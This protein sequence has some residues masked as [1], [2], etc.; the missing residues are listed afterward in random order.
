MLLE[1][2]E[3]ERILAFI[4][5]VSLKDRIAVLHHHDSDGLCAAAIVF[6][7][8]ERIRGKKPELR[9]NQGHS[10]VELKDYTVKALKE[11]KI[12]KLF[13]VDLAV[14][15]T[16]KSVENLE[17]VLGFSS[18]AV[19]D[20]H[21]KHRE[22]SPEIIYVNAYELTDLAWKYPAS[23]MCYD[24]FSRRTDL[25]DVDWIACV[26]ILGDVSYKE[27]KEFVDKALEKG[28]CERKE[29]VYES[30]LGDIHYILTALE[31][32]DLGRLGEM[33]DYLLEAKS[34]RDPMPAALVEIR[35]KYDEG[36]RAAAEEM[37]SKMVELA[38]G[39]ILYYF[40][41]PDSAQGSVLSNKIS[42]SEPEKLVVTVEDLGGESLKV[43]A[44]NQGLQI[45]T[46]ELLSRVCG[47]LGGAGGGHIP[48]SGGTIPKGR[49][50]EFRKRLV[51]LVGSGEVD[52]K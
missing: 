43:H 12:N 8:I 14:S 51:E 2:R 38:N 44:R 49:E 47:E 46:N 19:I 39:R 11:N 7:A 21:V 13:I 1:G 9:L 4:D 25:S 6:K 26:G 32:T 23:K 48:A 42:F 29:G 37:R 22:L 41:K 30:C 20:H 33:F 17:K 40:F 18:I 16:D 28:G 15:E 35:R 5:S 52:N 34:P 36:I 27:W 10:E 3:V 24:L 50:K 45:K 31:K